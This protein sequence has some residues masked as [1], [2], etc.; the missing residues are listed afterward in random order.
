M[1]PVGKLTRR[2]S[3]RQK[4]EQEEHDENDECRVG[5]RRC[6]ASDT[7]EAKHSGYQ[8]EHKERQSPT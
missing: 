3:A 6:G 2:R 7:A 5:D 8:R 1:S 4:T